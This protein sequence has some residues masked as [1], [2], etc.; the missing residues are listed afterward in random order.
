MP[1]QC[2]RPTRRS[3]PPATLA[4]ILISFLAGGCGESRPQ[5]PAARLEGS[6]TLNGAVL[7]TGTIQ[8]HPQEA[9][10]GPV[11]QAEIHEG[12]YVAAT[13]PLGKV[14]VILNATKPTGKMIT[15][16]SEPYPEMVSLIPE[17]Y[18]LGIPIQVT[19][20][21]AAQDFPLTSK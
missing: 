13:V 19:G 10:H 18:R 9:N 5:Y 4:A 6:V 15:G 16:Y 8:F 2:A 7:A 1:D 3:V 12:R 20:D 17:K 14:L 21:N 11:V